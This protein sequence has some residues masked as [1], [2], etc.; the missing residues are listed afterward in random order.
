MLCA[1]ADTVPAAVTHTPLAL[2]QGSV[3]GV[4]PIHGGTRSVA[5]GVS[6]AAPAEEDESVVTLGPL[7]EVGAYAL[8]PRI[9]Y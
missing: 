8:R 7:V 1:R 9:V 2:S 5:S 3:R 4:S 6:G